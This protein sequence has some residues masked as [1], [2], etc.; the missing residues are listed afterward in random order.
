[1]AHR[2]LGAPAMRILR[3]SLVVLVSVGLIACSAGDPN[4]TEGQSGLDA[5]FDVSG[6]AGGE[7]GFDPDAPTPVKKKVAS[8]KVTPDSSTIEIVNGDLTTVKGVSYFAEATFTDGTTGEL[9]TCVWTVDRIGLGAMTGNVFKPSGSVGGP[10]KVICTF[11]G[12]TGSA[13]VIVNLRD[14]VDSAGADDATKKALLGAKTIDPTVTKLLYPNDGTVFAR[15]LP[16]PELMWKGGTTSDVYM[17]RVVEEGMEL[18]TFFN[19]K[20]PA[21]ATIPKA[22]WTKLLDT[23]TGGTATVILARYSGGTAY[24]S[25]SQTWTL[26][27]ANLKGSIYYWRVNGGEVARIK[28]GA[29][30]PESFKTAEKC[31]GCHTVSGNGSTISAGADVYGYSSAF[32]VKTG[33]TNFKSST[34]S[35]YRALSH[36]GSV[37]AWVPA[38][39]SNG[40]RGEPVELADGKTGASLEPS[41]LAAFG[42]STTPAFSPDGTKIAF[43]LRD[44]GDGDQHNVFH[45]ADLAISSFDMKTKKVTG[46]KKILKTGGG[47]AAIFPTFSP[48]SKLVAYQLGT[49]SRARTVV[50][51]SRSWTSTPS[52]A[53]LRLIRADGTGDIALDKACKAGVA[54]SDLSLN[55]QPTFNPVVGGGYFWIVFVSMRPYGNRLTNN[56]DYDYTH[57][58]DTSGGK[59]A[60]SDCRSKQLWVAAIDADPKP[61]VDPS[62]PAFWLPGQDVTDQNMD[63]FWALDACKKLGEGC[64]AGFECCDGACKPDGTGAKVC[65]KPPPG[66]CAAATDKCVTS[67]DCCDLSLS[68]IAGVCDKII[69]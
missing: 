49:Q 67:A 50:D 58:N 43:G 6:D 35:G 56:V 14:T 38:L 7:T 17:L 22:E 63:G 55:F 52:K 11:E 1:M 20:D 54:T 53:D 19:A 12:V 64:D 8:I 44:M 36:D 39:G 51:T 23:T 46:S 31:I 18:T 15:G 25:T 45:L 32:D 26:S 65:V 24:V 34:Q 68:C 28:P 29:D 9:P 66:T 60:F 16:A 41:G 69:K 2:V 40:Y 10:G 4:K 30:K 37:L 3:S 57:C 27:T 5:D 42:L 13:S 59:V 47:K 21:R 48:D 61:G 62:H 33:T